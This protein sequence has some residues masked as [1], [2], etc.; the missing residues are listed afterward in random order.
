LE[1]WLKIS[2]SKLRG[3]RGAVS[4]VHSPGRRLLAA[5]AVAPSNHPP[6]PAI[7]LPTYIDLTKLFR[8]APWYLV[9]FG[10]QI[11][12]TE[13][14]AAGTASRPPGYDVF[15]DRPYLRTSPW[16][17]G[18]KFLSPNP[19]DPPEAPRGCGGGNRPALASTTHL[20]TYIGL[21]KPCRPTPCFRNGGALGES[22]A[23]RK[24]PDGFSNFFFCRKAIERGYL[25]LVGHFSEKVARKKVISQAGGG[26]LRPQEPDGR[27]EPKLTKNAKVPGGPNP[28]VSQGK[29]TQR[30]EKIQ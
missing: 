24:L 14:P 28:P 27:P 5:E 6:S 15:L 29:P 8:P 26:R 12:S 2:K 18:R 7:H 11:F 20:P 3:P 25:F 10:Q 16:K 17:T 1:N 19:G 13:G 21:T 23:V 4:N 22:A 30:I 9:V